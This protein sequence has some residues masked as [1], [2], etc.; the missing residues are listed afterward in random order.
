MRSP[1][2]DP[3]K[4]DETPFELFVRNYAPHDVLAQQLIKRI[5]AWDTAGRPGTDRLRIRAYPLDVNYRSAANEISVEKNWTRLAL[6][7]QR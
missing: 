1:E 4:A 6:D 3:E 2:A 7:W 5:R